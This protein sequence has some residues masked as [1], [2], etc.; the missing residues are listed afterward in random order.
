MM[1]DFYKQQQEKQKTEQ[2][3][4]KQQET[5]K[6][7]IKAVKE[8]N[9]D[10][11]GKLLQNFEEKQTEEDK[12][13]KMEDRIKQLEDKLSGRTTPTRDEGEPNKNKKDPDFEQKRAKT[14][15]AICKLASKN[16]PI[17]IEYHGEN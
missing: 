10:E 14:G 8:E 3:N 17:N 7:F 16:L 11:A 2:E 12:D 9:Y 13:K 15:I 4:K 1:T 6:N 5:F